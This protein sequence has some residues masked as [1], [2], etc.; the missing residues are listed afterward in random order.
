MC[1]VVHFVIKS[2]SKNRFSILLISCGEFGDD[3]ADR[4]SHKMKIKKVKLVLLLIAVLQSAVIFNAKAQ[5][6]K[7]SNGIL[8]KAG[9]QHIGLL[10]VKNAAFC[11][12]VSD[13]SDP[14]V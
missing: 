12:S 7:I 10:A 9:N 13:S 4:S 8:V 6:K 11:L 5:V 1:V 2:L 14:S 3:K